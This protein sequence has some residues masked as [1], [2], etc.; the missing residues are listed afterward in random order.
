[1]KFTVEE[2]KANGLVMYLTMPC[3]R[4]CDPEYEIVKT[5]QANGI[6]NWRLRC[7]GCGT[8][9]GGH[10]EHVKI[11]RFV[12][13]NTAPTVR[14]GVD[15]R[16]TCARCG[17]NRGV[18]LHHWAPC[19]VF[20]DCCNWP[21]NYLCRRCHLLWHTRMNGYRWYCPFDGENMK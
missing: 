8:V 14:D 21:M 1:V 11:H 20:D 7:V 12:N 15:P 9:S 18:E 3:R 4:C 16:L 6:D 17:D 5:I 2:L 10:I 13:V 19:A